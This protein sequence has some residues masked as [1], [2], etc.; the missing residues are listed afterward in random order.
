MMYEIKL[1]FLLCFVV[2]KVAVP[3][4]TV[5]FA[6]IAALAGFFCI[7]VRVLPSTYDLTAFK[8]SSYCRP[9]CVR[10]SGRQVP[11]R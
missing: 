2:V 7:L 1:R 3:I 9:V 11:L 8:A 5:V 4:A 10:H 6:V